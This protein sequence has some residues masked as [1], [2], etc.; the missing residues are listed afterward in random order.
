[1]EDSV[2]FDTVSVPSITEPKK[3]MPVAEKK[4]KRSG[5]HINPE[6]PDRTSK[7]F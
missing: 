3:I 7:F 5:R 2:V 1:V 6:T 4:P